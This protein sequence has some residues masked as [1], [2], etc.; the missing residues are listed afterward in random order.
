MVT[1]R[2]EFKRFLHV[3]TIGVHGHIE[4]DR[5][6]ENYRFAPGDDYQ[7]T[8]LEAEQ[9]LV[10]YAGESGLPY[11]IV[12]PGAIYGPGDHRLLKIFKMAKK[13]FVLMLG[14]GKGM[15]HLVHVDDLTNIMLL[16]ASRDE[17]LGET[18]I[19]ISND[20]IS[21]IDMGKTI[22]KHIG[23]RP[24]TI[25]LP[26]WPFLLAADISMAIFP[27]LGMEPPIY[28]RRVGFYM[29]DRQFDN[30]K[31]RTVLGYEPRYDNDTGLAETAHW[32]QQKGLI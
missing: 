24:R 1:G 23:T 22:G 27:K 13:G 19:G 16:A 10:E 7:L 20:P 2:P 15:Y 28:R 3:S 4:V 30:R 8:K 5:A 14:K 18:F 29:K 21:I 26:I 6:D 17:A 25:R 32:Y 12:R 31:V 9:W 11:A